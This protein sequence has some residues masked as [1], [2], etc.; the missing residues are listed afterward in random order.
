MPSGLK[1]FQETGD[2]HYITFSCYRRQPLMHDCRVRDLFIRILEE[3]RSRYGF[4]VTGYVV[5]PEHVHLLVSE[6]EWERLDTAIQVLKQ[7][8]AC[9]A[10]RFGWKRE[11]E[12]FWQ[13][14]Y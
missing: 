7:R 9:A 8:V 6:P 3:V 14:R 13:A 1:R 11:A 2:L 12:H 5:M 4:R 10:R